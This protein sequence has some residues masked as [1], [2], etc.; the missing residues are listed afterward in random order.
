MKKII[1]VIGAVI[2]ILL[3]GFGIAVPIV[4]DHTAKKTAETLADI[5]LPESAEL[6]ETFSAAGKLV[7]NGNGM[8]YFGA[9][10]IRTETSELD[11]LQD[12]YQSQYPGCTVEFQPGSQIQVIEHGSFS[13]KTQVG[14]EVYYIVYAWGHDESIFS[15]LDLRGH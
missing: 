14:G 1:S 6:C 7:G 15:E 4:N 2:L 5:P 8:Q 10:L 9:I 13:F 3:L 11:K 12:Y